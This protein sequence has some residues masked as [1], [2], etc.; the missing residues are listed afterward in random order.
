MEADK[1]LFCA[2]RVSLTEDEWSA[3]IQLCGPEVQLI[4]ERIDAW[5]EADTS[6]TLP[7]WLGWTADEYKRFAEPAKF[8]DPAEVAG[9]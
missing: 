1:R 5:H 4:H 2:E 3:F 8:F 9:Q 7:E 6:M